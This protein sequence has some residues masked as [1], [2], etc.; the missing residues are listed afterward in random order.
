MC[1]RPRESLWPG[2]LWKALESFTGLWRWRPSITARQITAE[3]LLRNLCR[4]TVAYASAP[5]FGDQI[6]IT[7]QTNNLSPNFAQNHQRLR[8]TF[9]Q[10]YCNSTILDMHDV[11]LILKKTKKLHEQI[12]FMSN[13]NFLEMNRWMKPDCVNENIGWNLSGQ[14]NCLNCA[15]LPQ[16]NIPIKYIDRIL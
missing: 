15:P 3:F 6:W 14:E 5:L 10:Y 9:M 7:R 11:H 16:I 8:L 12:F 1:C 13:S 2:S 4:C